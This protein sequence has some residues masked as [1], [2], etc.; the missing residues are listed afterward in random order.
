MLQLNTSWLWL[1]TD[2]TQLILWITEKFITVRLLFI[3]MWKIIFISIFS[4]SFLDLY[5]K[6]HAEVYPAHVVF[7]SF[8]P[9]QHAPG[10]MVTE[11]RQ[12]GFSPMQFKFNASKPDLTKLDKLFGLLSSRTGSFEEQLT[13]LESRITS[14]G[15]KSLIRENKDKSNWHLMA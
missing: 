2:S 7:V 15:L 6:Y 8:L 4:C 5:K 3:Y 14:Q 11:L 12:A 10:K 13:D 9:D 1:F